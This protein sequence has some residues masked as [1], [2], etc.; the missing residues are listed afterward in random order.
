MFDIPSIEYT[1]S[2][3]GYS[4][5]RLVE[6]GASRRRFRSIV[7]SRSFA[8]VIME[9][10]RRNN[11]RRSQNKKPSPEE[12]FFALLLREMKNDISVKRVAAFSKRLLHVL[13]ETGLPYTDSIA[14]SDEDNLNESDNLRGEGGLNKLMAMKSANKPPKQLKSTAHPEAQKPQCLTYPGGYDPRQKE[15]SYCFT[16][17]IMYTVRA[18]LSLMVLRRA[19]L[20]KLNKIPPIFSQN[21]LCYFIECTYGVSRDWLPF[22]ADEQQEGTMA[23]T[24][25]SGDGEVIAASGGGVGEVAVVSDGEVTVANGGEECRSKKEDDREKNWKS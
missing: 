5:T 7:V 8:V 9:N 16:S 21:P 12:I 24:V 1:T 17:R 22:V 18:F 13:C 6:Y 2:A 11:N 14:R 15:P 10:R 19:I 3:M 4:I 20:N 25:A 23:L